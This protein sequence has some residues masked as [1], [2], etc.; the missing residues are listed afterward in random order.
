MRLKSDMI[1]RCRQFL[2]Q[3]AVKLPAALLTVTVVAVLTAV[4]CVGGE[5]KG[6]NC[7]DWRLVFDGYGAASCNSQTVTL[8][9]AVATRAD[10][11][12]AGLAT[13]ETVTVEAGRVTVCRATLLTRKQLRRGGAPNPWEVAWLL[14]SYQD[15]DHFYA[16]VLKPNGWEVSKQNPAYPG[17]QQFLASGATPDFAVG[18]TYQVT[19]RVDTT[20]SG[21]VVTDIAVDGE[22]LVTISDTDAPYSF[23]PVAAYTEDAA[24]EVTV[25]PVIP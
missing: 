18:R 9:P 7:S 23:G 2:R 22:D 16:L 11:T 10:E 8:S 6:M 3:R 24:I 13:S 5:G 25:S 12:H 14:W 4:T 15:N 1:G 21:E 17:K 19:V 20:A